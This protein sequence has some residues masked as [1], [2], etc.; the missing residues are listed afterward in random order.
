M[1]KITDA[2]NKLTDAQYTLVSQ[3][4]DIGSSMASM[5]EEI[6]KAKLRGLDST[7]GGQVKKLDMENA[8]STGLFPDLKQD[9]SDSRAL[10][11]PP[12]PRPRPKTDIDKPGLLPHAVISISDLRIQ[13]ASTFISSQCGTKAQLKASLGDV[14]ERATTTSPPFNIA[15][16]GSSDFVSGDIQSKGKWDDEKTEEVQR[17]IR[18]KA[19]SKK[20]T[21]VDIGANIGWFTLVTASMGHKVISF[22]PMESNYKIISY[23]VCNNPGMDVHLFPYGAHEKNQV[24]QIISGEVNRGDGMSVCNDTNNA[25]FDN[26]RSEVGVHGGYLYKRRGQIEMVRIEDYIREDVFLMKIDVEG[27]EWYALQGAEGLFSSYTVQYIVAEFGPPM[28]KVQGVDPVKYLK[29]FVKHGYEIR[30]TSWSGDIIAPKDI[31]EWAANHD[32]VITDV[33]LTKKS[34]KTVKAKPN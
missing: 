18:Q 13:E 17:L 33:F 21:I 2:I 31:P 24:C 22:E 4:R 16:Y 7:I 11:P 5:R 12:P 23:N 34:K 29:W 28:M 19:T 9:T 25:W 15:V 3:V 1:A 10:S 14:Y 8:V 27:F 6:E 20:V 26:D 32:T 30:Q